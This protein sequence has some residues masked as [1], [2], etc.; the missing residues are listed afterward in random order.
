MN[1]QY[2]D[3]HAHPQFPA[4]D[5]DRAPMLERARRAGVAGMIAV[6]TRRDTSEA[7]VRLA[8][9][10]PGFVWAAA[11]FHPSH[12]GPEEHFDQSEL[13]A[14]GGEEF[15]PD[16]FRALISR[17]EV[18]AVGECGL[19]YYRIGNR[20][21]EIKKAQEEIFRGHID[22]AK[23]A[24]KP[25][26]IHCRNAFD[27]L[28]RILSAEKLRLTPRGNGVVHFFSGS[29]EDAKMLLHLGF[30]LGFGGVVTF[31]RAYDEALSNAPLSSILLETDAPYVAPVPY[32]GRRN[33]PAYIA[34]TAKKIAEFRGADAEEV[35][36]I[37]TANARRIFG[38]PNPE[39]A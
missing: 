30:A 24:G 14:P 18:A 11:G 4:F 36:L 16:E 19:D 5:P 9:D 27:D 33:E 25:L 23:E 3:T 31:A 38:I 10:Y 17:P 6:G 22:L 26:V 13:C 35:A 28:A 2:F 29:W 15:V 7:A 37:T 34:D 8:G 21:S 20:G 12:A 32:R 1:V 39:N